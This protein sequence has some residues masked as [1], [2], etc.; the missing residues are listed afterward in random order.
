[1]GI[2]GT[3]NVAPAEERAPERVLDN[4]LFEAVEKRLA[5]KALTDVKDLKRFDEITTM[6]MDGTKYTEMVDLGYFR[7]DKDG[8]K[9]SVKVKIRSLSDYETRQVTMEALAKLEH[10]ENVANIIVYGVDFTKRDVDTVKAMS[11]IRACEDVFFALYALRDFVSDA[12]FDSVSRMVGLNKVVDRVKEI[13]GITNESDRV[14]H[15]FLER[16]PVGSPQ[17]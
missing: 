12:T 17:G 15:F 7:T 1:M 2:S 11:A 5:E 10:M 13:S 3:A 4:S 9:V 8:E 6:L 14:I 16:P